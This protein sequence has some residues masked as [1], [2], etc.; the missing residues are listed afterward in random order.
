V[1]P[2]GWTLGTTSA[3]HK[4]CRYS[5]DQDGSGSVDQNAEH[6]DT[7]H[8]VERALMQQNFL[9]IMGDQTCPVAP[10]LNVAT[11]VAGSPATYVDLST[12]QHQP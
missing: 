10:A 12:V 2:Q 8:D 7:Y 11:T 5:A 6:P 3:D 1:V 4:V 9:I